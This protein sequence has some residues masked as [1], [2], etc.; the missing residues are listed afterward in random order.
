MESKI[1][2]VNSIESIAIFPIASKALLMKNELF[3]FIYDEKK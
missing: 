3:F 1:F 2:S